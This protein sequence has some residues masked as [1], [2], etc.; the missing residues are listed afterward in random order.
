MTEKLEIWD[1]GWLHCI[2]IAFRTPKDHVDVNLIVEDCML[3]VVHTCT[4]YNA[5]IIGARRA[6]GEL[7]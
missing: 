6:R 4:T 1:H 3:Y 2:G 7:S 5:L